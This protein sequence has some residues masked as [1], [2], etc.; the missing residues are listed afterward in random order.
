MYFGPIRTRCFCP[1]HL[2]LFFW[3]LLTKNFCHL[4][5]TASFFEILTNYRGRGILSKEHVKK[6]ASNG[7]NI[8][9]MDI[10]RKKKKQEDL[11]LPSGSAIAKISTVLVKQFT[12]EER[13]QKYA[14]VHEVLA[15]LGRGAIISAAILAPKSA[16][17]L[18]P[19][20]QESPDWDEWKHY[21]MSYL[22]RTLD[23]LEKAKQVTIVYEH[24]KEVVRLT[25]NGKRKI[26][27]YTIETL[28]VEKPK[29]W[30]G[31]WR[32][33]LYDIPENHSG[34]RDFIRETLR[35][36][37]FYAIQESVYILP[38][39]CFEQIE[40]LR[41][42]YFLGT[43]IQYMLVKHIENDSAYKTYFNLS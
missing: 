6:I 33:V 3:L 1:Q 22:K 9:R 26:L 5:F 42:Y 7:Q 39:P 34:M 4:F 2:V 38:Y 11:P 10:K 17:M 12:K 30:D 8:S 28:S 41:E 35:S 23:R 29:H 37:G 43:K 31:K 15:I 18:L 20:V 21:N 40:F 36:M 32:V 14:P 16:A 27:K 25:Q 24:G 13:R 19:L